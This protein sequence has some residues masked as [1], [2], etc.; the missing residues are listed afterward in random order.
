MKQK[1]HLLS[2]LVAII[3]FSSYS[4][5]YPSGSPAGK[6][7]SPG[8]G[9]NCS[10]CHGGT[11]TTT[12]GQITSNIPAS[13]YIAGQTYQ[14]TATNP[15]T[16]SGKFGFEVS[17]QN[18]T[19][20]QLG[21]LVAGS[22]SKLV[23]GTKYVTQ[24]NA[25]STTS[26]WTFGWVAPVA[27]T[28]AVTF[29]GAFARNYTGATTLSSLTVQ[30]ATAS[31]PATAGPITGPLTVCL[32]NSDTY[33]V[34]SIAG[35][36]SY[37]WSAPT[38]A[39]IVSGQGTTSVSV[40]FSASAISGN[41]SVYGSNANGNGAPSSLMVTVNTTPS[42]T[43]A[44]TG[45]DNPCQTSSQTYSVTNVSGIT[46]TWTVPSGSVITSGQGTNSINVTVGGNSGNVTVVP[47]NNCGSG[48]ATNL[49]ITVSPVPS[50]TS[51]ITGNS[52]PCQTTSQTYSVTSISGV[53]YAWN[54]PSGSV[55]TSGQGTNSVNVTI[56]AAN[57]N[58]SVIPSNSCGNGVVTNFTVTVSLVPAQA[59]ISG[60]SVPCQTSSQVYSVANVSGVTYTW[61]VPA[62]SVITSG[63]GTN[64]INVT[65]G[66]TN[67]NITVASSNSC[68]SGANANFPITVG[69][70]PSQTSA[71]AG[72]SAP[73]QSSSQVY[74]VSNVSG[75]SY[76]WNVP[77]GSVITSGQGTSSI[78]VTMGT[79]NGD[80]TVVPSNSCGTGAMS[81]F[82]VSSIGLLP[83]TPSTPTGP[84][85]VNLLNTMMSDYSTS[86]GADSYVWQISPAAAGVIS[87]TTAT[88]QVTWNMAFTGNVDISVKGQNACG[89]SGWSPVETVHVINT[90]GLG[91]DASGI[92]VMA[93][94]SNGYLTFEMNTN[95]NQASVMILDISGRVLLN[96]TIAGQGRQQISHQLKAGVYIVI[97]EA[98]NS[99]LN[100]KILVM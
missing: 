26:T 64:S 46:F 90:T 99:R 98:G 41:M 70:T 54:V 13:G 28:G 5:N 84:S 67:G 30:E 55:I 10:S 95:A 76:A 12:A 1:L 61:E 33:S 38:G 19:G 8:D 82:T 96:T 14:I 2:F 40:S 44:V 80:V 16:G 47:S 20:T 43:S 81:N 57:G 69:S 4:M 32:N 63:Q 71:I 48:S 42:P 62:G 59:T 25:N 86:A 17:P 21:T 66:T 88:A 51:S 45:I 65:V 94:E 9:S 79:N 87:G 73:C 22:G 29:Y 68:G 34:G 11:A 93:G 58:V 39:T 53:S 31:A 24:S 74:S 77:S 37:V 3:L 23:G 50:Q 100:R 91:D 27:G 52:T 92:R 6:T 18:V 36:T 97:V 85:Q 89:I 83:A 78:N 56:G 7:G 72:N 75:V 15:L 49:A 60:N 35:A